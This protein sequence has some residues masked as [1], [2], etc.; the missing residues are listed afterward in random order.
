M[1]QLYRLSLSFAAGCWTV[2]RCWPVDARWATRA[3]EVDRRGGWQPH[4]LRLRLLAAC[5]FYR[6]DRVKPLVILQNYLERRP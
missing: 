3:V 1:M 2:R 6:G 5:K 4:Q